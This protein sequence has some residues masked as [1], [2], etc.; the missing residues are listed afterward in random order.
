MGQAVQTHAFSGLALMF[1]CL[2]VSRG[3]SMGYPEGG[4]NIAEFTNRLLKGL[5]LN[6]TTTNHRD[7]S[8][9]LPAS[10]RA[11]AMCK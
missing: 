3:S 8:A 10:P 2:S 11:V 7:L 1:Q 5:S 6:E 9:G 4:A